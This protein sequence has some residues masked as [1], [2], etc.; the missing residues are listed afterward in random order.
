MH[1]D[2]LKRAVNDAPFREDPAR[3]FTLP[4][5]FYL[6]AGIFQKELET[7]FYRN[8]WY[9]G[10]VSQLQNS[11]DYLTSTIGDQNVFVVR[12]RNGD[13]R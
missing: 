4:A 11:G 1:S 7:I 13:V 6:D 9:A 8:W 3:S 10:H 12:D 5:R 2:I